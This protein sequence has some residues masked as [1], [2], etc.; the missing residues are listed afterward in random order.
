VR[1]SHMRFL[2]TSDWHL[3]RLFH[4]VHL[5]EDQAYVLDQLVDLVAEAQV[6]A[7]VI[8]G[9]LYDRAVPPDGAVALLSDVLQRIV[10]GLG[11]PV[12]A[13]AGNH[14]SPRRV[15][16]GAG[17]LAPQGL[18]LVGPVQDVPRVVALHDAHGPVHF[19]PL[20]YAEPS[21][22]RLTFEA[23]EVHGRSRMPSS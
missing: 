13:I 3:G 23:P 4:G 20:P 17:L 14:D 5:T 1:G 10:Q 16:F 21:D 6:D 18:H 9:D 22:V 15:G 2:H 8:A 11:V 7:L 12:I 19:H